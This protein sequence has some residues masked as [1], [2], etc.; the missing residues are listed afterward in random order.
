MLWKLGL[1]VQPKKCE[2]CYGKS[3]LLKNTKQNVNNV[4]Q[5]GKYWIFVE[6]C[7]ENDRVCEGYDKGCHCY[8]TIQTFPPQKSKLHFCSTY[9]M[10]FSFH[11]F[12]SNKINICYNNTTLNYIFN[13]VPI[14]V[15]NMLWKYHHPIQCAICYITMQYVCSPK[16]AEQYPVQYVI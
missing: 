5:C 9:V 6:M 13:I 12:R 3:F 11:H 2:M 16:Q 7:Y 8:N 14:L 1:F 15:Y 10:R 4:T